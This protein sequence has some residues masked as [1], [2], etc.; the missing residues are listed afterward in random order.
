MI[1]KPTQHIKSF[2]LRQG[3]MSSA[4]KAALK[5]LWP[6][7]GLD[8]QEQT[9]FKNIFP[10]VGPLVLEIGFGNG[11]TLIT[12]AK[13]YPE[14]N[15]IGIEVHKPG[16]GALLLKLK[17]FE[18]HNVR[19]FSHDALE[20]L[21]TIPDESLEAVYLLFPDPWPKRRHHKRRIVQPHFV[22]LIQ[23]KLKVLGKFH[24][25]TD[26]EDY[27]HQISNIL[28]QNPNL[29]PLP[30]SFSNRIATKFEIRGKKLGH[31]IWDFIFEKQ[32]SSFS[33]LE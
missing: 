13:T 26:W 27:A 9:N 7:Y 8:L 6:I 12:L 1:E 22:E 31:L 16:V 29:K 20:V 23:R 24:L 19:I 28:S 18:L 17:T 2:I 4:Q 14:K 15:F 30:S 11:D 5:T 32:D 10:K 25:A 3:H 21:Q 33:S